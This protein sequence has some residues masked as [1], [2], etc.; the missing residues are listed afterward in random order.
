MFNETYKKILENLT[1]KNRCEMKRLADSI[2]KKGVESTKLTKKEKELLEKIT[3][4]VNRSYFGFDYTIEELLT[5]C[6]NSLTDRQSQA[7]SQQFVVNPTRQSASEKAQMEHMKNRGFEM[8]KLKSSGEDSLRFDEQSCK[9]VPVKIEGVTSR[10]FDYVREYNGIVEYFTG[11]VTFGQG[12][13]QNG[14]KTEIVDFLKRSQKYLEQN[15]DSN[16]LFTALVDGNALT[17]NDLQ[18]YQNYTSDTVRLMSSDT[19]VP[20]IK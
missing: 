15:P 1:H 18:S 7:V 8:N 3:N 4:W 2:L 16:F 10:S 14:M 5:H 12:G 13:G 11:K 20:Y 17:E 19:Y 6:S 9:L